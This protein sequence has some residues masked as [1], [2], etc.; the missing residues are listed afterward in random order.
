MRLFRHTMGRYEK[1]PV[2]PG[3]KTGDNEAHEHVILKGRAG[4][5]KNDMLHYPYPDISTWLEKHD[6]YS[7]WEAELYERFL[8]GDKEKNE[9]HIGPTQRFKRTL[10]RVY[11][12][13]PL[14]FI[15]RFFYA[16]IWKR[17]FLDGRPG[18]ILCLLLTF[19][20]FL[21]WAKVYER[22]FARQSETA[23]AEK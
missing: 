13:L 10:K 21:S 4:Y 15:F 14:R 7:S 12:R 6:R 1:M 3:S 2:R 8:S 22:R 11:L 9:K 20:D 16:Y 23:A 18:F 17:G 5:L 19:Y